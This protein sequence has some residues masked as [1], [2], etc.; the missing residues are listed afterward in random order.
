MGLKNN[1]RIYC[2]L[3]SMAASP[4]AM[5]TEQADLTMEPVP[6]PE[7]LPA[8]TCLKNLIDQVMM[9]GSDDQFD[10]LLSVL[11]RNKFWPALQVKKFFDDSKLILL[12]NTYKRIDVAHFQALYDECRSVV[13]DLNATVGNNIVVTYG[14]SIPKRIVIG[15]YR[16]YMNAN[17]VCAISY[18]GTVITAYWYNG[19]WKFGTSTCPSV[20]VSRYHHPTK[21]HGVMFNEAIANLIGETAHE[22]NVQEIRKKFTVRL[23]EDYAYTFLLVHHE[24]KNI[25]DYTKEFGENYAQLLL[26]N[27][28]VRTTLEEVNASVSGVRTPMQFQS[29]ELAIQH[30][31]K[32]ADSTYGIFV[33]TAD[34][35]LYLVTSESTLH[36]EEVNLG[37]PNPWLNLMHV[38]MMRRPDYHIINYINEFK[39]IIRPV[40]N[41]VNQKLNPTFIINTAMRALAKILLSSYRNSTYY[42]I[43]MKRY[44]V[45]RTNNELLT[46]IMRFHVY[47]LR[48]I[49]ITDH[50]NYPLGEQ[51]IF[52]YL[53]LHNTIKNIRLLLDHISENPDTYP[54][55]FEFMECIRILN[56]KLKH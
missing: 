35:N 33:K 30:L 26:I 56:N 25:M 51:A 24:N 48:Q 4:N 44:I 18:E 9:L 41:S 42:N 19:V 15:Q 36:R 17:D 32:N 7:A 54:M 12:H 49:Q 34:G 50:V 43:E 39:P 45:K 5:V 3:D 2:K 11:R 23:N 6:V 10:A 21:T 52:S 55:P 40:I 13:L 1:E 14:H 29:S 8:P 37:H 31:E 20:D 53:C 38:Y 28:R 47:Q 27:S 22:S 16:S 46:S